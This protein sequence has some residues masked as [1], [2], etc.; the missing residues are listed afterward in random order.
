MVQVLHRL[1]ARLLRRQFNIKHEDTPKSSDPDP[2]SNPE[3]EEFFRYTFGRWIYNEREQMR[4][5]YTPFD[6]DA[7]KQ[8]AATA[9]GADR[10]VQ[11]VKLAEGSFN[12]IFLLTFD[13]Y[14][15][16]I[17]KVPCSLVAPRRLCTASEVATMDYARTVLGLPVPRIL[18]WSAIADTSGVGTEY[19]LMEY[20]PGVELRKRLNKGSFDVARFVDRLVDVE[21]KF[22]RF[23][24]SQIGSLYYKEDVSSELQQR[25]LYAEGVKGGGSD[26]F[27]IGPCV[28][29]DMWRGE[30]C[31]LSIDRGPWPDTLSYVRAI[32]DIEKEWLSTF[33]VPRKRGDPFRRP[34]SD[35][36]PDAHARLLDDFLAVLPIVLPSDAI[37]AP[38]LWHMDLHASNILVPRKGSSEILGLLD[39]QGTTIRPLFLQATFAPCVRYQGDDRIRLAPGLA[40]PT[41]PPDFAYLSERDQAHLRDQERLAV[42]HKYYELRGLTRNPVCDDV[43]RYA[44]GKYV[45]PSIRGASRTWYQ[46]THHL[47]QALLKLRDANMQAAFCWDADQ[48]ATHRTAYARLETYVA[49]VDKVTEALELQGDGWVSNERYDKM[50][51]E[52]RRLRR[53]WNANESG[54]PY[55]FQDGGWSWFLS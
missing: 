26:R 2:N 32:V 41:L 30:R 48:V 27:R 22:T 47:R 23:R 49:R 46:G 38:V 25:P 43:Q 13:N 11:M 16:L 33:A 55:P 21:C 14:V 18:S 12:K 20:L 15:N 52:S 8:I 17:A 31:H 36:V 10:C 7:L 51:R 4:I 45:V 39:W 54:G 9:A 44:Y 1:R 3:Y 6:V 5:R 29:F 34:G 53:V 37:C 42:I 40:F 50:R 28:D 24:F 35:N 19:I